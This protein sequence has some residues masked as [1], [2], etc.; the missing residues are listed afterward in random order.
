MI[1]WLLAPFMLLALALLTLILLPSPINATAWEPPK[2]PPMIEKYA[3]NQKLDKAEVLGQGSI[4]G[5]EDVDV[6]SQGRI[7]GGTADGRIVRWLPS[8]EVETVATTGGRPLGLHWDAQGKLIICDAFK[9]LLML[10]VET[11]QLTTLLTE[12]DGVPLVFTDDLE[13]ARDGMIYFSD[14]SIKYD[15]KHYMLDMLEARPWG[16][17]IRYDPATK[18]A[19]TL[20]RELYFA[21]GIALSQN[22]DFVLINETFRY[23]IIRYWISGPNAGQHDVFF[24]NLPGFPD[25]V[26]SSGRGTFWVALGTTRNRQADN[27]HPHPYLKNLVAKL[28]A[29]LRP[30]P[31]RYGFVLELDEAGNVVRNLQDRDGNHYPM[32]TSA[33][34]RNGILY[35]GSLETDGIARL[36]LQ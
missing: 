16:R 10:D 24:D 15:Q 3:P 18:E 8:G 28:P 13:I 20:L 27:L 36:P 5:P 25:G 6:D 33:Q 7:Y 19:T 9:G 34:E 1:K 22:N 17:L 21:N 32:I 12:V 2:A 23:R 30:Q 11:K 14:A 35:L 31:E 4:P 26:S 29:F